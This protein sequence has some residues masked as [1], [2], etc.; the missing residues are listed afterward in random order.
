MHTHKNINTRVSAP[1]AKPWGAKT[2]GAQLS[3]RR[4]AAGREDTSRARREAVGSRA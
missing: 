3:S 1:A 2:W 4:E